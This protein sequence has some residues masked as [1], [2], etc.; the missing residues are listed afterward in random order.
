MF[1]Y[2]FLL[3]L[4][5]RSFVHSHLHH[6]LSIANRSYYDC[7]YIHSQLHNLNNN[8]G[9]LLNAWSLVPYCRRDVVSSETDKN[10]CQGEQTTFKELQRNNITI[11]DLFKWHASIDTMNDYEKFL[12]D[13]NDQVFCKCP[14][15]NRFGKNCE[16]FLDDWPGIPFENLINEYFSKGPTTIS[17]TCY[18]GLLAN[19][20]LN[21]NCLNWRQ[22]CDGFYD[23]EMGED[24]RFCLLLEAN[25]CQD[26][27][28]RCRN[29]LCIPLSFSFDYVYDCLDRTDESYSPR[30]RELSQLNRLLDTD[31][32]ACSEN[33]SMFC[34]EYSCYYLEQSC[35]T[36]KCL[37]YTSI[38]P[39]KSKCYNK[40]SE[41]LWTNMFA[42]HNSIRIECWHVFMCLLELDN[43]KYTP[44]ITQRCSV[45]CGWSPDL[46][47]DIP[48]FIN[49]LNLSRIRDCAKGARSH[50]PNT[51]FVFPQQQVNI[52][53]PAN[54]TMIYNR[55]DPNFHNLGL[56]QHVCYDGTWCEQHGHSSKEVCRTLNQ[57]GIQVTNMLT[58]WHF[59][60]LL[61][62]FFAMNCHPP[63]LSTQFEVNEKNLYKCSKSNRSISLYRLKDGTYDC[64]YHDDESFTYEK[65]CSFNLTDRMLC[66]EGCLP[67]R[68]VLAQNPGDIC[69]SSELS[70][71]TEC[72]SPTN[73]YNF[74]CQWIRAGLQ[75]PRSEN[76]LDIFQF[77]KI[78]DGQ[79]DDPDASDERNCE[80]WKKTCNRRNEQCNYY[81]DCIDGSD[82]HSCDY[83]KDSLFISPDY[84]YCFTSTGLKYIH[85]KQVGD[86]Q[87]DC[88]GATDERDGYCLMKYPD[89]PSQRFRCTNSSKCILVEHVCDGK[90]HCPNGDDELPCP[91]RTK[92][93]NTK[94]CSEGKFACQNS[95]NCS[96]DG[97]QRCQGDS[98]GQSRCKNQEDLWFCD[99]IDYERIYKPASLDGFNQFP[100]YE[101]SFTIIDQSVNQAIAQPTN[102]TVIALSRKVSLLNC[103]RG[104]PVSDKFCFCPPSYYG[105]FC[106]FQNDRVSIHIEFE[107]RQ[108]PDDVSDQPEFFRVIATLVNE[109]NETIDREELILHY[110]ISRYKH[111]F[112]LVYS[113]PNDKHDSYSISFD[114]YR[115]SLNSVEF[116]FREIKII[117]FNFLPVNRIALKMNLVD[118][119]K[120]MNSTN[121]FLNKNICSLGR[122]GNDCEYFYNPC[123]EN[124]PCQN[125]GTCFPFDIRLLKF[126]FICLC[127]P[128]YYG[129]KCELNSLKVLINISPS[130]QK[131]FTS[132]TDMNRISLMIIYFADIYDGLPKLLI[133]SHLIY[134]NIQYNSSVSSIYYR[135]SSLSQFIFAQI[136]YNSDHND[137]FL[138]GLHKRF[139]E[140]SKTSILTSYRCPY[141][142][143]ILNWNDYQ[144]NNTLNIQDQIKFYHRACYQIGLQCFYDEHFMCICDN[145]GKF[146]CFQFNH[147]IANCSSTSSYCLNNGQCRQSLFSSSKL[148]FAC[149]CPK[150]YYGDLCQFTTL[151]YTISV[152]AL[153]INHILIILS[154]LV[155]ALG[156]CANLVSTD[157]FF[158][159]KLSKIGCTLYFRTLSIVGQVGLMGFFLKLIFLYYKWSNY[160][161]SCI[162]L[163]FILNFLPSTYDWLTACIAVERL[164]N[165]VKGCHFNQQLSKYI[166]KRIIFALI[167]INI[168][169]NI[170]DIF[171]RQLIIDPRT[172]QQS[173]CV[174][175]YPKNRLWLIFLRKGMNIFH[176]TLPFLINFI[177]TILLL[178][179]ITT[180]KQVMENFTKLTTKKSF[181]ELFFHEISL[182]KHCFISPCLLLLF[183]LPRLILVFAFSCIEHSWQESIYLASYLISIF[184]MTA[185]FFIFILPSINFC[186]ELR[187]T[188]LVRL[189]KRF[190]L[191]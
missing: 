155:F 77:W 74:G 184:P 154:G 26:D 164:V 4:S 146:E 128:S 79:V 95:F 9:A 52:P 31:Y 110:L 139:N 99:L 138:I 40:E 75:I 22:F 130:I 121:L 69:Y 86:G 92:L 135:H 6:T 62:R 32:P 14:T 85:I 97:K 136:F 177:S 124:N 111:L 132:A 61:K 51:L 104:L 58:Y 140:Y 163:E 93:I 131:Q 145:E 116:L 117:P 148:M 67:K 166:A 188:R 191:F 150:C 42:Y 185:T 60:G 173:W 89:S 17:E 64:P 66:S 63:I 168:L 76:D 96:I 56:P 151:A 87:I 174:I 28:Y 160:L 153:N 49:R 178:F 106:Q 141:V 133:Q 125:G 126:K 34:E 101:K 161:L 3:F 45:I 46:R 91:W 118:L 180:R 88:L 20:C 181:I 105:E 113:N 162:G 107:F 19:K 8:E 73:K 30:K 90:N 182:I 119:S 170:H 84:Y 98:R 53:F 82:E 2:Y 81:W 71:I 186:N 16:Y 94:Y 103:H 83:N 38:H 21:Q 48:S 144:L 78:C 72:R 50:C 134:S 11:V 23:C 149:A 80:L 109:R 5:I 55:S 39:F 147:S 47:F 100:F 36:F 187:N 59:Y 114:I 167:L 18:K 13:D 27:E 120:Q 175:D 33:P 179:R 7:F 25:I 129:S 159:A 115:I 29:G 108:H 122:Y 68:D 112:Y 41:L 158:Q 165:G 24:E 10:E 102:L 127:L 156:T 189:F 15:I 43:I 176:I 123:L 172:N 190:H 152:D 35:E 137:Y 171:Y 142:N 143:D 12:H 54:V 157:V 57:L 169:S 183:G 70:H 65:V 44:F 1:I 37:A